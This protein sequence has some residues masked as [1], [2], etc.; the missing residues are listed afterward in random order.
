MDPDIE[1][2]HGFAYGTFGSNSVCSNQSGGAVGGEFMGWNVNANGNPQFTP[3]HNMSGNN[4]SNMGAGN[5]AP[6]K[7]NS[8]NHGY[9]SSYPLLSPSYSRKSGRSNP[10]GY[11]AKRGSVTSQIEEL[12]LQEAIFLPVSKSIVLY[13]TFLSCALFANMAQMIVLFNLLSDDN[14]KKEV[15]I[16]FLF[17]FAL[18]LCLKVNDLNLCNQIQRH[19][20]FGYVA[21]PNQLNRNRQWMHWLTFIGFPFLWVA[22]TVLHSSEI[23]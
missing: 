2:Q 21:T 7:D 15:L 11:R 8:V 16:Y 9:T 18:F 13:L 6:F 3:A 14:P 12:V 22:H 5:N 23:A 10:A 4:S 20:D 1:S 17:P 19:F